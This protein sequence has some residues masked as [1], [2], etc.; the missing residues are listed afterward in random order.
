[1]LRMS[2]KKLGFGMMRLPLEKAEDQGTIDL[3]QTKAMVDLFL[4]KG[5]TYFDTAWMYHS[6]RSEEAVKEC[7]VARHPRDSYTLATKLHCGFFNTQEERNGVFEQQLEK[8][9]AG[10]FDYYLLHAIDDENIGKYETLDCFNFVRAKREEGLAR[11]IGF[12]FHGTPELLDR[13]L[14]EHPELEFV[15]LQL[16]YLDWDSKYVQSGKCYEIAQRH[17]KA[18]VVMEPVKGGTLA[19]VPEKAEELLRSM[20]PDASAASWAIRFAASLPN[21]QVVL[22]GMSDL[23]QMEDNLSYMAD[24]KPLTE[25]ERKNLVRVADIIRDSVTIPC[26]ACSY[27]TDGCPMSIAIP[28]YFALYNEDMRA[29]GG[30]GRARNK[31]DFAQV[32]AEFGKP[33][34]CVECGQCEGACPQHLPIIDLLKTVA[35]RYED[36]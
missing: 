4:E 19:R 35:G 32:A 16:N 8:T 10:Y 14:T 5:F 33:G 1:M 20:D 25:E 17:G 22:S 30:K 21:V 28:R 34:D 26:T 6:F 12:S 13:V 29:T 7:L 11:H 18:V 2:D 9:G 15:Q 36:Q 27:C 31:E 3:E 24:F 23:A